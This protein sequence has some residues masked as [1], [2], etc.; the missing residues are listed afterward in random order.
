M[1][2]QLNNLYGS[3]AQRLVQMPHKRPVLGSN[4]SGTTNL[5]P[6]GGM[7]TRHFEGVLSEMT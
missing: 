2:K 6:G 4:P 1:L 7:Y 5:S 3:I